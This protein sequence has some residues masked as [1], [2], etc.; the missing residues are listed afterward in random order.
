LFDCRKLVDALTDESL[1][2]A[3]GFQITGFAH[4]IA[5]MWPSGGDI[6]AKG[7][8]YIL[9]RTHGGWRPSEEPGSC[10]S[11]TY[12]CRAPQNVYA[13]AWIDGLR[14]FHSVFASFGTG[15]RDKAPEKRLHRDEI[16]LAPDGWK[17]M[18]KHPLK[19]LFEA[20]ATLEHNTLLARGTF[21]KV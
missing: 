17:E 20:A 1:H 7:C 13:G 11:V 4:T 19:E 2:L 5:A 18:Q 21:Q 6:R 8:K 16:P 10:S 9:S 3:S 12:R 15:L 14:Q